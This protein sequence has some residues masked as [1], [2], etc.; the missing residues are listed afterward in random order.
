MAIVGLGLFKGPGPA[1]SQ[2]LCVCIAGR[3]QRP[4]RVTA[5]M[6]RRGC[7]VG[8]A[9][10]PATA[11]GNPSKLAAVAYSTAT[12]GPALPLL[13]APAAAAPAPAAAEPA[14]AAAAG[15]AT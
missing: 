14:P 15:L 11:A 13:P 12:A 4:P 2:V 8:E 1:A 9:A 10:P 5:L 6:Y 3:S 7:S